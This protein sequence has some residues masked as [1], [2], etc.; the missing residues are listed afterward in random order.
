MYIAAVEAIEFKITKPKVKVN[1]FSSS[2]KHPLTTT[3]RKIVRD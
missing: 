2:A 3:R 1:K